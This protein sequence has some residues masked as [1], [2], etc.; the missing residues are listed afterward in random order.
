MW[1]MLQRPA[2]KDY[3]IGTNTA[4]TVRDACR[5]AF[6]HVGLEWEE[7]V[8]TDDAL[9]RPTEITE[10]KGD[11]SLAKAELGWESKTSFEDLLKLMVDADM[12]RF[13]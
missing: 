6:S 7:H 5:I 1:L 13:K 3:V 4:H 2:P 11:Y 10:L 12:A 9:L 8:V